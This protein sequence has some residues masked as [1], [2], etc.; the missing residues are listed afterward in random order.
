MNPSVKYRLSDS[1]YITG[2]PTIIIKFS[3]LVRN[4]DGEERRKCT[5]ARGGYG[6]GHLYLVMYLKLLT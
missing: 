5:C 3:P 2:R 1:C 4:V 6:K